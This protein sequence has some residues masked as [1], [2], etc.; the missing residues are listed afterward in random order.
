MHCSAAQ[1]QNRNKFFHMLSA[2]QSTELPKARGPVWGH[3]GTCSKLGLGVW[4]T[5]AAEI[6]TDMPRAP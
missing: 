1:I 6:Q 2:P 4:H 5:T 3:R